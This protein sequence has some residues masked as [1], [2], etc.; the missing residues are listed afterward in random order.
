MH[1]D[2]PRRR[3]SMSVWAW[4][5]I[6]V[7]RQHGR[8]AACLVALAAAGTAGCR[9][10][11]LGVSVP[12]NAVAASQAR[13]SAGGEALRNG[14]IGAFATGLASIGG[15][16][17]YSGMM[18]DEFYDALNAD[19]PDVAADSRS[20]SSGGATVMDMA[21]IE[22][23]QARI[24]SL[25]AVG[26]L[27][28]NT[29]TAGSS[30]VGE[31]FAI[32]G[33]AEV[34]LAEH[35]CAG[36][37]LSQVSLSSTVTPGDPLSTDSVLATAAA[38]FDSAAVHAAGS[39]TIAGL[40]AIGKGRALLDRGRAADAGAAVA[41]VPPSFVYTIALPA[42]AVDVYRFMTQG[43]GIT[44]AD[45]KG[46]NG[47]QYV[48][49]RDARLPT[50]TAGINFLTGATAVHP[51]KF[52]STTSSNGSIP[53][54]DGVEGGLITAEQAL[55]AGNA[56]GWLAALNA[57][58]ANFTTLRG[59]YP[60]DTSYHQLGP[61]ADP[62]SDSARVTLTFRERA[63]WLYGTGHRLGDLRRLVHWYGR[64]QATVF[65]TGAYVNG[66]ASSVRATYGIDVN[67]PIGAVEQGN[68]KFHGC[69]NVGA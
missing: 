56:A 51:L 45:G 29:S 53:L 33:Y 32:A 18:A 61:L 36:I 27:E 60:A 24:Q 65:P 46:T 41:S 39:A 59:P 52:G 55:A 38:H 5:R 35:M 6:R 11:L 43:L 17:Q 47:L 2:S 16:L 1:A 58:R 54:G 26:V 50:D 13:D 48:S 63:F 42:K 30:D 25:Q 7:G 19:A 28:H 14:A 34:F 44:M 9:G 66:I 12:P 69:L 57:L 21:Y 67:F 68:P 31:A 40:G 3:V 4:R 8:A 20:V 37:P 22:L 49:A 10:D 62:G 23:Q 15:G 64:D